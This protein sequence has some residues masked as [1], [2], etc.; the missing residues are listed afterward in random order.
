M[1]PHIIKWCAPNLSGLKPHSEKSLAKSML[2]YSRNCQQQNWAQF[3]LYINSDC[4]LLQLWHKNRCKT[5]GYYFIL[6][7]SLLLFWNTYQYKCNNTISSMSVQF[8]WVDIS[9]MLKESHVTL[10]HESGVRS[11]NSMLST[12]LDK[13]NMFDELTSVTKTII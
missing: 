2:F 4:M 9:I 7:L 3:V 5:T 6:Q 11:R 10:Y 12:K 8:A 1:S 13:F